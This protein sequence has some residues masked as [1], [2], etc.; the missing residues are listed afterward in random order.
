M[1]IVSCFIARWHAS[2]L[3]RPGDARRWGTSAKIAQSAPASPATLIDSLGEKGWG[4]E[5]T[6]AGRSY[7]P[8]VDEV[9]RLTVAAQKSWSLTRTLLCWL[10]HSRVVSREYWV[11]DG[12][13]CPANGLCGG[14]GTP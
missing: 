9:Q 4:N 13:E 6:V 7:D 5:I 12:V 11:V 14:L 10:W 2:C 1:Y 3:H 8:A